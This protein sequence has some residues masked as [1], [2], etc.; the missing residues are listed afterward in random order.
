MLF[1]YFLS[2]VAYGGKSGQGGSVY[3]NAGEA[4]GAGRGSIGGSI[5]IA[6]GQSQMHGGDLSLVSGSGGVNSGQVVIASSSVGENSSS[7][8]VK[9]TSGS[10]DAVG[11]ISGTVIITTGTT[12]DTA[13]GTL[14]LVGGDSELGKGADVKILAGE[15]TSSGLGGNLLLG[16]LFPEY[17]LSV[18]SVTIVFNFPWPIPH[19]YHRV[20]SNRERRECSIV[21]YFKS[22]KVWQ[23]RR[24][25]VAHRILE[26]RQQWKR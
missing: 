19:L 4:K 26:C 23:Q 6:A 15:G 16:K 25:V 20:L 21:N 8:D 9:L 17:Y 12:K 11:A 22:F 7:G 1:K 24:F 18:G 10:A 14:Q 3:I 2:A 5:H 13:S